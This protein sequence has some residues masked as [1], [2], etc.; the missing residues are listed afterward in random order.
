MIGAAIHLI[1]PI[2]KRIAHLPLEGKAKNIVRIV[3]PE[4]VPL[5]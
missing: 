2:R 4:G 5:M 1:R 3:P